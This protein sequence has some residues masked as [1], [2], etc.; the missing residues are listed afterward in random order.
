MKKLSERTNYQPE[1]KLNW[2]E[3][4]GDV[5]I[6]MA[7]ITRAVWCKAILEITKIRGT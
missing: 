3:D 4:V 5:N 2:I 1:S 6:C 7:R